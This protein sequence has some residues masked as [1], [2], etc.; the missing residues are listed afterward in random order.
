VDGRGIII[1]LVFLGA[2]NKR[3]VDALN[4]L[5]HAPLGRI[6]PSSNPHFSSLIHFSFS[7]L[8]RFDDNLATILMTMFATATVAINTPLFILRILSPSLVLLA[9][10]SLITI[11]PLPPSSPSPITSVVVAARIPRRAVILS[12]LSFSS[13]TYLLDGLA[14]VLY[15]VI[16]KY[17]PQQ[18]GIDINALIGLVAFAG[19]AALGSWKDVNGV[20]VWSLKRLKIAIFLSLALDLA[21]AVLYG[22]SMPKDSAQLSFY[23]PSHQSLARAPAPS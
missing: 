19:L 21:Q 1:N 11:R 17:W 7:L 3:V 23:A 10:I 2:Y 15:A 18:T 12:C 22:I 4:P 5:T 14:F 13:F 6:H 16:N 20:D 8:S 9:T